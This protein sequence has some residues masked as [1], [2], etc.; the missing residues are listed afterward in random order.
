MNV[1]FVARPIAPKG[2]TAVVLFYRFSTNSSSTE[3]Q[4]FGMN[5]LGNDLY[6]L[7]LNP[8]SLL[9]GVIPFDAATLQYQIVVQ[10]TD[11]DTSIRTPVFSDIT[12]QACGGATTSACS[13]YTDE[14]T[15]ISKSC[16]WGPLPGTRT[17]GC[18][19]P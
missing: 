18:Q 1:S 13:Q 4:S 8:N 19:V 2:I 17:I 15:C 6:E 14:R 9:G 16:A 5:P 10:Q 3:F 12:I 7:T 11:G